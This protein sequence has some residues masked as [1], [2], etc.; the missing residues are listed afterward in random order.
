MATE[1]HAFCPDDLMSFLGYLDAN[2]LDD[3]ECALIEGVNIDDDAQLETLMRGWMRKNF[4]ECDERNRAAMIEILRQSQHW[5]ERQLAPVFSR[6]TLPSGQMIIDVPRFM[7][8]LRSE[9][10]SVLREDGE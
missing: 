8:A 7:S 10:L 3:A 6:I 4:T 9:F 5:S 2:I 1:M